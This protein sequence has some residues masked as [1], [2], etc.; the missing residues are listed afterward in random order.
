MDVNFVACRAVTEQMLLALVIWREARG[1][2]I[3]C[4][5]A[6]GFTVLNRVGRPSWWG[7]DVCDVIGKAW[8]YSS[9]TARGD[10]QLTTWPKLTDQTWLESL[11]LAAQ[12]LAGAVSTPTPGADSYHDLSV[13]TPKAMAT[14][15][16]CGQIGR[17]KFFDVDHDFEAMTLKASKDEFGEKLRAW[18]ADA[19]R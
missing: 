6:V 17:I 13:G 9:M 4:R 14:G 1:E 16:F 18:L 15:R 2:S 10:V 19:K 3:P 12:I 7:R 11:T 5:I 8:Q